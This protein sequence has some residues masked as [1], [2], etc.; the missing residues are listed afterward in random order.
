MLQEVA[1][2]TTLAAATDTVTITS[3]LGSAIE[4][5]EITDGTIT[6]ADMNINNSPCG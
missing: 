1:G 6:E 5:T 3:D 4:N 2:I